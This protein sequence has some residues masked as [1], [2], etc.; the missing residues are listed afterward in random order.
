MAAR[1]VDVFTRQAI[2]ASR[3]GV[4]LGNTRKSFE[5]LKK[6]YQTMSKNSVRFNKLKEG[7]EEHDKITIGR[8]YMF[9]YDPKTK[10]KMPFWDTL[11]LVFPVAPAEG[12]FYGLNFHY[13]PL[14]ER[15]LLMDRLYEF[16]NNDNLDFTTKIRLSYGLLKSTTRLKMFQPAFKRYLYSQMR[17]RFLYIEP[18]DWFAALFLPTESFRGAELKTVWKDSRSKI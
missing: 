6:N 17:S 1:G 3:Q 14:R 2:E 9:K 7:A 12:G 15:A 8:M 11:P 5:W 13:L 16:V 18:Q 4:I 10:E